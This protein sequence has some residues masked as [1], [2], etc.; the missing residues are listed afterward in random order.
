MGNLD[1][2]LLSQSALYA[3]P[4]KTVIALQRAN[5]WVGEGGGGRPVH[6]NPEL[7]IPVNA[8]TIPKKS[9]GGEITKKYSGGEVTKK[10]SRGEVTKKSSRGEVSKK[11][12]LGEVTKKS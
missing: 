11:S 2:S 4:P 9:P 1:Y 6:I 3:H 10:S 7:H 12:S 5:R 8:W